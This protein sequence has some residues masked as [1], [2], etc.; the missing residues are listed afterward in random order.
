MCMQG[1]DLGNLVRTRGHGFVREPSHVE[2]HPVHPGPEETV[3]GVRTL[4]LR[5]AHRARDL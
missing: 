1:W 2:E 4:G 5:G 3:V